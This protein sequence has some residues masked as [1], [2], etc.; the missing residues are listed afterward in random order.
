MTKPEVD[1]R[2]L[3]LIKNGNSKFQFIAGA[4]PKLADNDDVHQ[5]IVDRRLQILR[6]QGLIKYFSQKDGWKLIEKNTNE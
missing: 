5:R 6:K 1:A 2:I 3:E 4:V